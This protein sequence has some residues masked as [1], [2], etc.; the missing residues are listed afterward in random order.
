MNQNPEFTWLGVSIRDIQLPQNLKDF[1][2]KLEEEIE[3][4]LGFVI[5]LPEYPE[6]YKGFDVELSYKL[7]YKDN[8]PQNVITFL[9]INDIFKIRGTKTV[10]EKLEAFNFMMQI[11]V[12]HLQGIYAAKTKGTQLSLVLPP[13]FDFSQCEQQF[14]KQIKDEW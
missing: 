5:M 14:L 10:K 7:L 8:R 2:L 13:E 11:T 1:I 6:A 4:Q 3:W 9:K 12:W